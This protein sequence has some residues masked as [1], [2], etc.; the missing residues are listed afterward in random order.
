MRLYGES[1]NIF[2][3]NLKNEDEVY[4]L[5]KFYNGNDKDN[6]SKETWLY[7]F[8]NNKK[9][10]LG[11]KF[12][13][14]KQEISY[15][16]LFGYIR[17]LS[18]YKQYS[19]NAEDIVNKMAEFFGNPEEK[20]ED[21]VYNSDIKAIVDCVNKELSMKLKYVE[22]NDSCYCCKVIYVTMPID[23]DNSA[24]IDKDKLLYGN[25]ELAQ[26]EKK[27]ESTLTDCF[28]FGEIKTL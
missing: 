26:F 4:M 22:D 11:W 12:N 15:L 3:Q 9:I 17:T 16:M 14:Q 2:Y 28:T 27:N 10:E 25:S 5:N 24:A 13:S 1:Q 20:Y 6:G 18:Q 7:N 8:V 19:F 21:F 23:R